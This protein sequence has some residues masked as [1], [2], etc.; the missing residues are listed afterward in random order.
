MQRRARQAQQPVAAAAVKVN[1]ADVLG[2]IMLKR[3]LAGRGGGGG[4]GEVKEQEEV[5][6]AAAFGSLSLLSS[7]VKRKLVSK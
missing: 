2:S 5:G 4:G 6:M 1:S 7:A 3:Q